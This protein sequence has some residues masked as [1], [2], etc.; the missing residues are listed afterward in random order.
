MAKAFV[1]G[2][3]GFVGSHLVDLLLDR[4]YGVTCLVRKADDLRW[5]ENT[6]ARIVYGDCTDRASL[7][8]ALDPDTA[9][10]FH[11]AAVLHADRT[12]V[13][14]AVNVEGTRNIVEACRRRA[15]GL[16]RLVYTSSAVAAGPSGK[17]AA[18]REEDH[19]SPVNHYGR[20]K[21]QA[22]EVLREAGDIPSTILRP[23]LVYGPRNYHGVYSYFHVARKGFR[24]YLG[25]GKST[26]VYV[27]D[28]VEALLH[29]AEKEDAAG[30]IYFV[31]ERHPYSYREMTD[32]ISGANGRRGL[33]LFVPW[34]AVFAAGA[35]L[36]GYA[37]IARR[38]PV[39][40]VRRAR[41]LR[42]RY[43]VYDTSRIHL[44]LD[45][46]PCYTLA[47]GAR[48]TMAWY[49]REGWI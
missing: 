1:T 43:W 38:T 33:P 19:C 40:T 36:Q 15:P 5:L 10:I 22:E 8:R 47:R 42:H 17:H 14:H 11:L 27:K 12:E 2:G 37:K 4:G 39:F 44:E 41:D 46:T 16:R 48:E 21:L 6:R 35:L 30:R 34:F 31:G 25:R 28:L 49:D 13:Y 9:Y 20:S 26:V 24:I 32:I 7:E 3:A 23:A 45:F 29:A 18:R